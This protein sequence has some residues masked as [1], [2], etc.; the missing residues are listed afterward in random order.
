M[1]FSLAGR[2]AETGMLGAVISTSSPAVG[3]RCVWARA[4]AGVVLTQNVTNPALGPLGCAMMADGAD[5]DTA[6]QRL[7]D[8]EAHPAYRQL[9]LLDG[10]GKTAVF[11]GSNTLG[12]HATAA[13]DNCVAAGNLLAN[14]AV[15]QA[16]I[17]SFE[18][19]TGHLAER[20]L[21]AI[22]AGKAAGGE[23]G[24]VHSAALLVYDT[25]TWPIVSLRV[26]W[27]GAPIAK[28]REAWGVYQPQMADYILRAVEPAGAPSYGVPGDE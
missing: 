27:D 15:P 19:T 3:A 2:C 14:T 21:A 24:S 13:G 20:L 4:D 25:Q 28:L 6:L 17:N 16:M 11:S 10:A 7:L 22:E 12:I 23:M 5:A 1:T 9:A 26:D 8:F 18:T